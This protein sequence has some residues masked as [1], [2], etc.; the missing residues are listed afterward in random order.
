MPLLWIR[1]IFGIFAMPSQCCVLVVV[2]FFWIM[3]GLKNKFLATFVDAKEFFEL[4]LEFRAFA[5]PKHLD[6]LTSSCS[7]Q[8]VNVPVVPVVPGHAC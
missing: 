7:W 4:L 8:V 1:S 2:F 3:G 5:K 6:A